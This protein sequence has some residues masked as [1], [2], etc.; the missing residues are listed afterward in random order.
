MGLAY[1]EVPLLEG[2]EWFYDRQTEFYSRLFGESTLV[3][4]YP[5]QMVR[6]IV[7]DEL[8]CGQR[9]AL[10]QRMVLLDA[11]P[12]IRTIWWA[13]YRQDRHGLFQADVPL[14]DPP[15]SVQCSA[16]SGRYRY[17]GSQSA[18]HQLSASERWEAIKSAVGLGPISAVN[19]RLKNGAGSETD[20]APVQ[21]IDEILRLAYP[22]RPGAEWILRSWP[23]LVRSRVIGLEQMRIGKRNIQSYRI[24]LEAPA[25]FDS[26]DSVVLYYGRCGYL[27]LHAHFEDPFVVFGDTLGTIVY[28]ERETLVDMNLSDPARCDL[29]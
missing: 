9:Y 10:E 23:F 13:R 22:L 11:Y 3:E 8:L 16:L 26:P 4:V 14:S 18:K 19:A 28:E 12:D 29:Q 7:G 24:Q 25:V 6:T 20:G 15:G 17:Q 2:S 5:G 1:S 27:G 21:E